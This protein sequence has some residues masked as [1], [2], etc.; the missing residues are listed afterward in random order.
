MTRNRN[1]DL[2]LDITSDSS[3]DLLKDLPPEKQTIHLI[4]AL[5]RQ[6][7]RTE[8]ALREV[9]THIQETSRRLGGVEKALDKMAD[10]EEKY[11][12]I[13]EEMR[14]DRLR[15]EKTFDRISMTLDKTAERLGGVEKAL[16][17]LARL[18]QVEKDIRAVDGKVA[19]LEVKF[20]SAHGE[21]GVNN[22]ILWQVLSWGGGVLITVFMAYLTFFAKK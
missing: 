18:E 12:A 4:H 6:R 7:V 10:L 9:S 22:K 1:H 14:E 17:E 11:H 2:S 16:V 5:A 13:M 19:A 20:A 3:S 8:E 15:A 21:M